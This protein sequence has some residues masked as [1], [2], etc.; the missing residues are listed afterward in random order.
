[1]EFLSGTPGL[2]AFSISPLAVTDKVSIPLWI[3]M[4]A[5]VIASISGVLAAR[6]KH[7]DIM[8]AVGLAVVAGLGGGLLRDVILQVGDVYMTSQPLALPISITTAAVVYTFPALV[9]HQDRLIAVLDILS[10]GLYAATGADKAMVYGFDPLVCIIMGFLTAVGGGMLRDI[11]MGQIPY[12]FQRSNFYA[13]AAIG[14]AVT[15]IVLAENT[16]TSRILALTCCVVVTSLLRFLSVHFNIMS[17]DEQDLQRVTTPIKKVARPITQPI[18]T[19]SHKT[20]RTM[21][22]KRSSRANQ[23]HRRGKRSH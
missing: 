14:G 19:L 10:V 8:G 3:E 11:C 1:M 16:H 5:I 12:I 15:Y 23:P 9:A 18:R 7:L 20:V 22:P 17:P 13:F 6:E 21:A 4:A 2:L